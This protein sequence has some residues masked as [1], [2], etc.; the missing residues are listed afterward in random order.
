MADL[1]RSHL[2]VTARK[3]H[4]DSSQ[5]FI[6]QIDTLEDLTF[7]EK[8]A[9]AEARNRKWRILPGMVYQCDIC[10]DNGQIYA[11]KSLPV[12]IEICRR[13]DLWQC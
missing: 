6:E 1:I 13:L 7:A 2:N 8:R 4:Q 11:Y 10:T 5:L 9:I 3:I 12:F